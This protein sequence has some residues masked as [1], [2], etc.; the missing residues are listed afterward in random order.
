M[1]HQEADGIAAAA[2]TKTFI[3]LLGGGN[4]KRRSFFVVKRTESQVIG[5]SFLQFYKAAHDIDDI[6]TAE[7]L[8]YGLL[9]DQAGKDKS[10]R[11]QVTCF[12]ALQPVTCALQRSEERRVG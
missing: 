7:Y 4:G 6:Y 10:F 9:R 12:R 3:D 1:L 5:A 2:A 8:L 11:W